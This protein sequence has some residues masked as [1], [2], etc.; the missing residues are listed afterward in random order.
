MSGD[1][2]F[3][4]V[5]RVSELI[6]QLLSGDSQAIQ[7]AT[8]AL[9]TRDRDLEDFLKNL[10]TG[11]T[12]QSILGTQEAT[13]GLVSFSGNVATNYDIVSFTIPSD[14]SFNYYVDWDISASG[15]IDQLNTLGWF[16]QGY[17]QIL[18]QSPGV[19]FERWGFR[20][21]WPDN[22]VASQAPFSYKP[23]DG[24]GHRCEQVELANYGSTITL[25]VTISTQASAATGGTYQVMITAKLIA[26]PV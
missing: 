15:D 3:E 18:G 22:A 20:T 7:R 13:T 26:I 19:G 6:P 5:P 4:F 12:A 1:L 8:T 11:G 10:G 9:E 2:R 16:F 24:H 21:A 17:A 23:L 14:T 25:R